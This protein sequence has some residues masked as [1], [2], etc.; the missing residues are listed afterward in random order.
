M[1]ITYKVKISQA[2]VM[3]GR[4]YN[5]PYFA[6]NDYGDGT[7][8]TTGLAL[9]RLV[10][11]KSDGETGA[12]GY[13]GKTT[14]TLIYAD[15]STSVKAAGFVWRTSPPIQ[16]KTVIDQINSS[17]ENYYP[18][19]YSTTALER[20]ET[21][22]VLIQ[23]GV[24]VLRDT[25]RD[26]HFNTVKEVI[27]GTVEVA[28]GA[29]GTVAGTGTAFTTELRVGDL[30]SV[31]GNIKEVLAIAS[32][33][34]LTVTTDFSGAVAASTVIYIESDLRRQVFLGEDGLFT[35]KAPVSGAFQQVVGYVVN[36]NDIL[37]NLELDITGETVS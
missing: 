34:S 35:V 16:D 26:Y 25:A 24:V 22:L 27:T 23:R 14:T 33:T 28:G 2:D 13:A 11:L 9:G 12:D 17:D 36:G 1:A 15:A 10:G 5:A 21:P 18:V 8:G 32:D 4:A 31:D 30:I 6:D 19:G 3:E 29:L 20:E 37:V 7:I